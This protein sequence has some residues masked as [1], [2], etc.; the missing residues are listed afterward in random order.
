MEKAPA[1]GFKKHLPNIVSSIRIIGAL[2]LPFLMWKSWWLTLNLPILGEMPAV[3]VFW[4]I[5]FLLL[6][7][8]DKIDGTLS[9]VLNAKSE[10]G[11]LL[12]VV[13][14]ALLLLIGVICVLAFFARENLTDLQFW[15]YLLIVAVVLSQKILVFFV[16]LKYFGKGNA[17]HSIPHKAFAAVGYVL[18]PIW[19]ATHSV[20]FWSLALLFALMTYAVVDEIIYVSR[21]AEYDVD[22]RGHGLQKYPLRKAKGN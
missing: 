21:T 5:F 7:L 15:F 3:P 4:I 6:V 17:L 13:G 22:F 18:V 10:L 20:P 2:L 9:R 16:A 8:S 14:D 19:A 1:V 11:A 12:D